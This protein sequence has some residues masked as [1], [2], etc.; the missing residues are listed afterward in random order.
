MVSG[1]I[2]FYELCAVSYNEKLSV[3]KKFKYGIGKNLLKTFFPAL[4]ICH[5]IN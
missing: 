5:G 3:S 2:F 4:L 1:A